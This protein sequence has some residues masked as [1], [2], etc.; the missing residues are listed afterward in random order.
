MKHKEIFLNLSF[1]FG[2]L[3]ITSAIITTCLYIGYRFSFLY[4]G[5]LMKHAYDLGIDFKFTYEQL[6]RI[7]YLLQHQYANTTKCT[8]YVCWTSSYPYFT[9]DQINLTDQQLK[10]LREY[11]KNV[12]NSALFLGG[13]ITSILTVTFVSMIILYKKSTK[14][15]VC[16]TINEEKV[17]LHFVNEKYINQQININFIDY[18]SKEKQINPIYQ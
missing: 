3:T 11:S 13:I 7:N 5:Y 12:Q 6:D 17:N 18:L 10:M 16:S 9:L 14:D 1:L 15:N 2:A 4:S 8:Q